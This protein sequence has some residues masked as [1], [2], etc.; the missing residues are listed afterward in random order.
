MCLIILIHSKVL[1]Q[2]DRPAFRGRHQRATYLTHRAWPAAIACGLPYHAPWWRLPRPRRHR[3][4]YRLGAVHGPRLHAHRN[5]SWWD[6][7]HEIVTRSTLY[8][9]HVLIGDC[10]TYGPPH[11]HLY[12]IHFGLLY[13]SNIMLH[14]LM[15]KQLTSATVD[16]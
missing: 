5:A 4:G 16:V 12:L 3:H 14:S 9:K 11:V 1:W 2:V 15:T 8:M 10:V 7:F 13:H 6:I